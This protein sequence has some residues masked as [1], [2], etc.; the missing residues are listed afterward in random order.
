MGKG[1]VLAPRQHLAVRAFRSGF[2]SA[3]PVPLG[4]SR[5]PDAWRQAQAAQG[6][7]THMGRRRIFV[8]A[9]MQTMGHVDQVTIKPGAR[10][11]FP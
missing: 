8:K 11:P 10:I 3:R 9:D 1:P 6:V 5:T 2:V 7:F 4:R